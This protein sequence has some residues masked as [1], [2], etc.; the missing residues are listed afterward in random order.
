VV[1]K[2]TPHYGLKEH[3]SVNTNHGYV[4]ATTMT[5]TSVN[6]TNYFPYCTV[7][8]RHTKQPIEKEFADKG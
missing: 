2:D 4:L 7:Y 5:L 1:Q 3:T 6:D 8:S